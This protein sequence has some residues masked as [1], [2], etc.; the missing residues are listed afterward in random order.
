MLHE[1]EGYKCE[2]VIQILEIDMKEDVWR[3][4]HMNIK[5]D[6]LVIEYLF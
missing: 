6:L 2:E 5:V 3:S 1:K 4:N